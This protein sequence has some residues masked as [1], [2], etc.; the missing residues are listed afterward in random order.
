MVSCLSFKGLDYAKS[1]DSVDAFQGSQVRTH[2]GQCICRDGVD[3]SSEVVSE[4]FLAARASINAHG[5]GATRCGNQFERS[6]GLIV[7][8]SWLY[9]SD[10]FLLFIL[11]PGYAN[12]LALR[13]GKVTH[14]H[15]THTHTHTHTGPL[16]LAIHALDLASADLQ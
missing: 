2:S 11:I 16:E 13:A 4:R 15:T 9:N 3:V 8:D 6:V 10:T 1:V 14:T 12:L 7:V 5:S